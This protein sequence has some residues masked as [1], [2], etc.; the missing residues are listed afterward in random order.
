MAQLTNWTTAILVL[1]VGCGGG[2]ETPQPSPEVREPSEEL[3]QPSTTTVAAPESIPTPVPS[4]PPLSPAPVIPLPPA[5]PA[6]LS[7]YDLKILQEDPA[8]YLRL[9]GQSQSETSLG[10]LA[11]DG[12]YV[13]NRGPIAATRLP[14]GD[15]VATFDGE[16]QYL[17]LPD[18]DEFS[19]STTGVLT[20]EAWV[21]P[22]ATTFVRTE[23]SGYV[24]WMGKGDRT[25]ANGNQE[26]AA[27][28]YSVPNRENRAN[29]I[30]GYAFNPQG[31]L[32]AGSYLQDAVTPGGWIHYVFVISTKNASSEF[33]TGYT[34]IYKNGVLRDVDTLADYRIIPKNGSAPV[35]IGTRAFRSY[36]RGAIGKVAIYGAELSQAQVQAHYKTMCTEGC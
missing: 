2:G 1:A 12:T 3:E 30:S 4:A 17:E 18:S 22:D 31:G 35:R 34:K 10:R 26:W 16:S 29:R 11:M 20:I 28:I 15:S 32:G 21:R 9:T 27:R 7:T 6:L 25:G 33:P 5:A 19:V 23:G 8:I 13:S 36:F 24:H 14:N